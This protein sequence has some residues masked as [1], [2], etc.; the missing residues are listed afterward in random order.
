MDIKSKLNTG[1]PDNATTYLTTFRDLIPNKASSISIELANKAF[2]HL[3]TA[4]DITK[5]TNALNINPFVYS[6]NTSKSRY[7]S[8]IFIGIIINIGASRKS[9]AG[10]RQF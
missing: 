1:E 4:K 8:S 5:S 10:Y 9:I 6:L 7:T 2:N 3:L